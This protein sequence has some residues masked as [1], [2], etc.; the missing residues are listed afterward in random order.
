[1]NISSG[2]DMSKISAISKYEPG[3]EIFV[4]SAKSS[5]RRKMRSN[6]GGR[7]KGNGGN[8]VF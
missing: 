5:K 4:I 1:M 6:A 8:F 2:F 3:E 7:S